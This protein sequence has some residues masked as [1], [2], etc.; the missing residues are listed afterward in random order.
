MFTRFAIQASLSKLLTHF[1][2]KPTQP[3]NPAG[4]EMSSGLT[5]VGYS[6]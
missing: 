6:L 5:Y 4:S 2:L 1:V 3:F